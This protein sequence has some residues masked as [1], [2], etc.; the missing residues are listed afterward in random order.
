MSVLGVVILSY[1][2]PVITDRAVR[3]VLNFVS[4]EQ[5]ALIHNGSEKQWVLQHQNNFPTIHHWDYEDNKGFSGGANRAFKKAFTMWDWILFLTNDT[6]LLTFPVLPERP[7]LYSPLVFLRHVGRIDYCMGGFDSK[8]GKIWHERLP[9]QKKVDFQK[10]LYSYVPGTA[11]LVHRSV[12]QKIGGMDESCHTYW[13]DVDFGVRA[14]RSG[15]LAQ[16]WAPIKVLHFGGK[17]TRKDRF[18]TSYLFQRN[19]KRISWRH[20]PWW[21]KPFLFWHLWPLNRF[22]KKLFAPL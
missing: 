15:F 1:N 16:E 14:S 10:G 22:V 8:K 17:T 6:Q 2:H 19:R 13:E 20:C 9:E 3:S 7:G 4:P 5:L 18:Y 11:F 21:A 12:Y